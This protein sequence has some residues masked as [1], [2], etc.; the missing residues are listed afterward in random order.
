MGSKSSPPAAPD[1]AAA[2]QQTAAGNLQN[3]I[4]AQQGSM[5]NQ[6]TPYGSLNYQQT[7]N[8]AGTNNPQYTSNINLNPTG[9]ALL[10][11][12]NQSAMGLGA[13]QNGAVGQV[14]DTM[15]KPMDQSSVQAT[16]DQA[17]KNYT[18]RLDPQWAAKTNSQENALVNQ[19]LRP[20]MEGYD[21]AMRDFNASKNDAY[22]QANTA[23]IGTMPQTYQLAS[24]Q[25]MQPLNALNALRTG[26][27]VTNP[28]FGNTP[29]QQAVPGANMAQ[30]AASQGA[31]NQGLY[32][33]QV[34]QQNSMMGG[35]ASLGAA[36]MGMYGAMNAPAKIVSGYG[37]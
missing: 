36:G 19:G 9:Q 29:Q 20:G 6:N 31:Y 8:W 21:N 25:Y 13:L 5:V 28:Q 4:A 12:A 18:S 17:Y 16:A 34:G 1:Y 3:S 33:T 11:Y 35:L 22:T 15:S 27:Q 26:S 14:A 7:G 10:D 24:A 32:N 30:A 37:W 23:A 2:A